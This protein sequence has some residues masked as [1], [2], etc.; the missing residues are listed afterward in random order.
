MYNSIRI[1]EP[2]VKSIKYHNLYS[3]NQGR[4]Y[5][6]KQGS[7]ALPNT[8]ENTLSSKT[9]NEKCHFLHP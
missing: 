4:I 9:L 7:I 1:R 8:L 3:N 5:G 2:L 6:G